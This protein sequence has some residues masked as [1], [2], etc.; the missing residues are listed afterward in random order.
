MAEELNIPTVAY[1]NVHYCEKKK[2]ILKEIIVAN[3]G[4]NGVRHF[5]YKEATLEES[6]DHF[7]ALPPQHLLTKEEIIDNWLFLNDKYLIEK[8]IFNYP[9]RLV[10]K[11]KEVIIQQ[12]PLNYSNTESI[13]RE[14][15]D[16]IQA[17]TQRTNEIF[18]EKWP[19]FVK[20]RMEKE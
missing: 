2:N 5:L 1:H 12:P 19:T 10:E 20:E 15:N 4:M 8:L 9:Q 14:E 13:K 16:L 3:E 17:Y 6:K 18:G 7:A 11:I